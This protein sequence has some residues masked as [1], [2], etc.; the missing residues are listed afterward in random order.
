MSESSVVLITTPSPGIAQLTLNRPEKRNAMNSDLIQLLMDSLKKV[1]TDPTINVVMLTGHGDHFC[2]GGDIHWMQ[3]IALGTQRENFNDASQLAL[4]LYTLYIFPK[5]IIALMH[6]STLGGGL[7]LAA[8]CDIAIA[9][10][11]ASFC[12][13]E[14]KI[15]LTPSVISPYVISA[16][17]ERAARYYFL[18]AEKFSAEEAKS[19][20]LI[21]CVTSADTLLEKGLNIAKG[22]LK[23]SPH[24]LTEVKK[25]IA[26]VA[27]EKISV[28][29]LEFT[30]HHLAKMRASDD[31][32]EGLRAFM[33]KRTPT[34][35]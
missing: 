35:T 31:A 12:F 33:G 18:T 32:Q 9:A 15:G 19:I 26:H 11:D 8:S 3:K 14:A 34:W 22:L 17:G 2:A 10:S 21:H 1:A 13:S 6:G 16:I 28:E 30:A 7:G 24:S 23:N 25:L 4:L 5:P 27:P 29:L 20:G